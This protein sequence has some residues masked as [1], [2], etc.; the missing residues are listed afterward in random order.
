MH[1]WP[2]KG[3]STE[4]R[5]KQ[6]Y[7]RDETGHLRARKRT[8]RVARLE[9]HGIVGVIGTDYVRYENVGH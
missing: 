9:Q 3:L 6:A 4:S 1:P 7:L 8:P 2:S 5:F